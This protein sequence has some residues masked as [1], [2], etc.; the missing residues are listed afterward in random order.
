MQCGIKETVTVATFKCQ[1]ITC[2]RVT[3][4]TNYPIKSTLLAMA[5]SKT[6]YSGIPLILKLILQKF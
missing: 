3:V 4:I 5:V 2:A 1:N 6:K